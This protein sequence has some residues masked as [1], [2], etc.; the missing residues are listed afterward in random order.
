MLP[1]LV[2]QGVGVSRRDGKRVGQSIKVETQ[3][4][5]YGQRYGKFEVRAAKPAARADL[6]RR[7]ETNLDLIPGHNRGDQIFAAGVYALGD[8]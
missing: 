7:L 6:A 1:L 5:T 4:L 8:S 2:A 3:K